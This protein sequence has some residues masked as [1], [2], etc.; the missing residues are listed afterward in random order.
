MCP[1]LEAT[2]PDSGL[3]ES[4]QYRVLKHQLGTFSMPSPGGCLL[5]A[6]AR[7]LPMQQKLACT[8]HTLLS[9]KDFKVRCALV[10]PTP[11]TAW[12]LPFVSWHSTQ[13][14]IST[15]K[16]FQT[17]SS[18]PAGYPLIFVLLISFLPRRQWHPTPV[19]LPGKSHGWRSLVGCSPWGHEESNTTE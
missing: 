15:P 1:S 16:D 9:K 18:E 5:W 17:R 8:T 10:L 4:R 12:T 13:E 6:L 14:V 3:K 7:G 19:L 11:A 2:G